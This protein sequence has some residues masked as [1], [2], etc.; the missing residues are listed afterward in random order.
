MLICGH[1]RAG[2]ASVT[3]RDLITQGI[4]VSYT[5]CCEFVTL[6]EGQ[7]YMNDSNNKSN[8]TTNEDNDSGYVPA[9]DDKGMR[10]TFPNPVIPE[11]KPRGTVTKYPF[12]T[13]PIGEGFP[14]LYSDMKK[15]SLAPYVHRM[16]KKY[17]KKFV[18]ID[19]PQY[20]TWW[21]ACVPM[22]EEEAIASSNGIVQ[23]LDRMN[24]K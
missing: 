3:I 15:I 20:K 4:V 19:Q 7:L 10:K 11:T 5:S 23:A 9:T 6:F 17:G 16:G 22:P 13:V 21:I 2:I 8:S 1:T 14:V 12:K 18:I 24:E